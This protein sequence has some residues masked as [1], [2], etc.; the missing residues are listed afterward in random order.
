MVVERNNK[1]K[2]AAFSRR[3]LSLRSGFIYGLFALLLAVALT[4]G[5]TSAWFTSGDSTDKNQF[6]AGTLQVEVNDPVI[7]SSAWLS[8]N[9]VEAQYSIKNAG[10]K[11]MY[12]RSW[13]EGYWKRNYHVNTAYA[14][15]EFNKKDYY[16]NQ[17]TAYY[18]FG[19]Y[20][21]DNY[22]LPTLNPAVYG[23]SDNKIIGP[24]FL[25]ALNL[26][27]AGFLNLTQSTDYDDVDDLS[28]STSY[29][30]LAASNCQPS[31]TPLYV[32]GNDPTPAALKVIVQNYYGYTHQC[33]LHS[34]KV[35]RSGGGDLQ[36]NDLD[37]DDPY[38]YSVKI[39]DKE[40][41]VIITK[42]LVK[43][44][45]NNDIT[46]FSFETNIPI[47]HVFAKGGPGGNLYSYIEPTGFV[48]GINKDCGLLQ[49][50]D[51]GWSHITFYFCFPPDLPSLEI[52]KMVSVDGENGPWQVANTAPGPVIKP[53]IDPMFKI[54]V[55]NT[56]N[57]TLNNIKVYDDKL[58]LAAN[59]YQVGTIDIL[60]PG[61][62]K[63]IYLTDVSWKMPLPTQN[64]SF[65]LCQ[66]ATGW[67]KSSDGYFYYLSPISKD[68][69]INLCIKVILDNGTGPE[70]DGAEF[71]FY[72]F[73]EAVQT[74]NGLVDDNWVGHPNYTN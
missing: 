36:P 68:Q 5:M 29:S 43:D 21:S 51:S 8:G 4:G 67:Y 17:S 16:S 62:S 32:S 15:V 35:Q 50:I 22:N 12:I 58:G 73:F 53:P 6:T 64:V 38:P 69:T 23:F 14:K 41:K 66:N 11:T 24:T 3:A 7:D 10:T 34:V 72:S 61:E 42:R 33:T 25:T 54:M 59:N 63:S 2:I 48:G 20:D 1:N 52:V 26:A 18:S 55:T 60:I 27:T 30:A 70:Y 40:F 44:E 13:F 28:E 19:D 39:D 31:V 49:P 46:V 9:Y 74:T 56:G 65:E 45:N 47:Y 57:V 71:V 37:F